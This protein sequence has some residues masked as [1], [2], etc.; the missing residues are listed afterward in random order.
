MLETISGANPASAFVGMFQDPAN[1]FF[2]LY[3]AASLGIA[4]VVFYFESR[5]DP[6]LKKAGLLRYLFP[7]HVYTHRSAIADY[8]FFAVNKLLFAL[9]FGALIAVTSYSVEATSAVLRGIAVSPELP[10]PSWV[11]VLIATL[12]SALAMDFGLWFGHWLLHKVPVLWE[13]HKVH[14]SAEVLTPLTA[15]RVHPLE[16]AI[17]IL[18]SGTLGGITLAFC[19]FLLGPGAGVFSPLQLNVL[20]VIFFFFGFHLR[21]SHIWLPYKGIWGKLFVSPAHHQLHHSVAQRHWDRN[22]GFVFAI[23]DW[24]FG[25]LYAVDKREAI[26][27]G[28]NGHEEAEYHSVRAMY[29]LPFAKAWRRI[30]G[31]SDEIDRLGLPH[32]PPAE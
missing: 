27:I 24:M 20:V 19:R 25:T 8:W 18:F 14:H 5:H 13:F 9:A 16:D 4:C 7:K 22:L 2:T 6:E 29:L 21:H 1:R 10:V 31:R 28:M 15:G 3:L 32:L 11:A 30:R 23:W 12:A 26:Q 17:N